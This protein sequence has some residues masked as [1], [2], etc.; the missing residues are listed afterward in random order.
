MKDHQRKCLEGDG[1]VVS[2]VGFG[3]GEEEKE[4]WDLDDIPCSEGGVVLE[5]DEPSVDG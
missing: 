3:R 1:G 4:N 2:E 5:S